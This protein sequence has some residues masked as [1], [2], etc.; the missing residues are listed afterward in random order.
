MRIIK[1]IFSYSINIAK[2]W[3]AISNYSLVC[4]WVLLM[5]L[6]NSLIMFLGLLKSFMTL[7]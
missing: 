4:Y 7:L 1:V 2:T 6:N 3:D 5:K